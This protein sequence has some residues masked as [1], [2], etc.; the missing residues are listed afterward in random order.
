MSDVTSIDSKKKFK[1]PQI[2]S[3][4]DL[5]DLFS[6]WMSAP[7][8]PKISELNR[9]VASAV[10]KQ[11][12]GLSYL[13]NFNIEYFI[14]ESDDN[15]RVILIVTE[16]STVRRISL[17]DFAVLILREIGTTHATIGCF[18][19]FLSLDK[20]EC[21][22]IADLAVSLSETIKLDDVK[23]IGR[24]NES[25][26]FWSRIAFDL[27]YGTYPTIENNILSKISSK[28]QKRA[29]MGYIGAMFDN[30]SK[31]QYFALLNSEKGGQGKG[32]IFRIVD[33]ALGN[34]ASWF[35]DDTY[36]D[37]HWTSSI[38]GK[39]AVIGSDLNDLEFIKSGWFKSMTGGD[40]INYRPMFEKGYSADFTGM[41]MLGSNEIPDL[42]MNSAVERRLIYVQ[43][44]RENKKRT[45]IVNFEEKVDL[46]IPSFISDCIE[47]WE[48]FRD[49]KGGVIQTDKKEMEQLSAD[50]CEEFP[51]LFD[52][53]FNINPTST[54]TWHEFRSRL[55]FHDKR[56]ALRQHYS[57]FRKWAFDQKLISK[58][59]SHKQA[60][61]RG[62][63]L[64]LGYAP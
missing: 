45:E 11:K 59:S 57:E 36:K 10:L 40:K 17:E 19:G 34:S 64:K 63:S 6:Y 54:I 32:T 49:L 61:C 37:K 35:N 41:F 12:P 58:S 44:N 2:K 48:Y 46:E 51:G 33:Y 5:G 53:S 55:V 1:R 18:G 28:T 43:I 29:L 24:K 26:L 50:S 60:V 13:K 42:K 7:K 8:G 14:G 23:H 39:R 56:L 38:Q 22:K 25:G 16:D 20:K 47:T 9:I 31:T 21:Q 62:I 52:I 15:K 4:N 27:E 3:R 30:E